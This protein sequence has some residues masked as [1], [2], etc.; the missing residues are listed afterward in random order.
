MEDHHIH[1]LKKRFG[2]AA[3]AFISQSVVDKYGDFTYPL[4]HEL[5]MTMQEIF[6]LSIHKPGKIPAM[7][8][9]INVTK[10]EKPM[11]VKVQFSDPRGDILANALNDNIKNIQFKYDALINNSEVK[12][13]PIAAIE[14]PRMVNVF[15]ACLPFPP[16]DDASM[17]PEPSAEIQGLTPPDEV[18]DKSVQIISPESVGVVQRLASGSKD[19]EKR[20]QTLIK[21]MDAASVTTP[22]PLRKYPE[23]EEIERKLD[24]ASFPNFAEFFEDLHDQYM[25]SQ[26]IESASDRGIFQLPPTLFVGEPGIGKTELLTRLGQALNVAFQ[27][28]DLSSA[29]TTAFFCGTDIHWGNARHGQLFEFL[30]FGES[31]NPI[32]LLDELDKATFNGQF[33]PLSPLHGLLERNTSRK[34]EDLSMPGAFIDASH[35]NWFAAANK[36]DSVPEQILSRFRVMHIPTPT[37]DQMPAILRS[38]YRSVIQAHAWGSVFEPELRDNTLESILDGCPMRDARKALEKAFANAARSKRAYIVPSDIRLKKASKSIGFLRDI[39]S[40]SAARS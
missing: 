12:V 6:G 25:L 22:K 15:S 8:I 19:G 30:V 40:Q 17:A 29:Q 2:W 13:D 7:F 20:L 35:I 23:W 11:V 5:F 38:I 16:V 31:A 36:V 32:V 1:T 28:T 26:V 37:K 27:M 18:D 24:M 39:Q 14:D 4:L 10:D 21:R 34:F 9:Y 33:D 3:K